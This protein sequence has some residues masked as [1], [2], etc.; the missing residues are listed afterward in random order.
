MQQ[1]ICHAV[2]RQIECP[3]PINDIGRKPLTHLIQHLLTGSKPHKCM[4]V[5]GPLELQKGNTRSL[6]TA[7]AFIKSLTGLD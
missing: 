2:W 1:A 5:N 6:S 3:D 7:A 4:Q